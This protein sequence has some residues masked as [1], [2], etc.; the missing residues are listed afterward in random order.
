MIRGLSVED[1]RGLLLPLPTV[2]EEDG[3]IDELALRQMIEYYGG[4]DVSTPFVVG[5]KCSD[6][7]NR[8]SS[9]SVRQCARAEK[10]GLSAVAHS[11]LYIGTRGIS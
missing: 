1:I 4:A 8:A 11:D 9:R 7:R 10:S 2:F 6:A 5:R 3:S